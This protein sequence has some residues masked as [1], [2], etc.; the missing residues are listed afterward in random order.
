[1]VIRILVL[2]LITNT[3]FSQNNRTFRILF[4]DKN[5]SPY[6]IGQPQD[7]LSAKAIQRRTNASIPI[8]MDDL[9]IIQ[10][11]IDSVL[12]YP[13]VTLKAKSKWFNS[14]CIETDSNTL[15]QINSISFVQ[16]SVLLKNNLVSTQDDKFSSISPMRNIELYVDN[17]YGQ[18]YTQ[19]EMLN[20]HHL[21]NAGFRGEGMTIAVLDAGFPEMN[22]M[23]GFANLFAD[24]RVLGTYNFVDDT[25]DVFSNY[26]FHGTTVMS[27]M[28][29]EIPFQQ[30]GTAPKANYYF[31]ITE[32]ANSEHLLEED[33]WVEAAE[34][35]DS[36]GVDVINSS[37][38]YTTFDDS[39]LNHTYTD[40]NGST[41][42]ISRGADKAA[43]KGILVL[44]SAGNSGTSSWYYLSAPAD[45]DSILAVGAVGPDRM[46]ASFSSKGPSSDGDVKPNVAAQGFFSALI[47]PGGNLTLGSGT[48]FASPILCGM[49]TCLWQAHPDKT[50]MDILNAIQ[51][52]ASQYNSPDDYIGF[53]IPDFWKAHEI[54][55]GNTTMNYETSLIQ[56]YPNPFSNELNLEVFTDASPNAT[57]HIFDVLG[58]NLFEETINLTP[59]VTNKITL[60]DPLKLLP[61]GSYIL[62]IN[63]GDY[64]RTLKLEYIKP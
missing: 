25:V 24:G 5:N 12:S 52:S 35:A 60:S 38:G 31:F 21:H 27:C 19:I 48:S 63:V 20:G 49:A 33:N 26:H 40:M 4:T 43:S 9:P 14:I 57:V 62:Q 8:V 50:N 44:N 13:N 28:G 56:T 6:S 45:A 39:T 15:S 46:Y 23:E 3:A 11:Y 53:G 10:N 37:L 36:L 61:T 18:A 42:F 59:F 2:L 30:V 1:M 51:Q 47:W 41:T 7:F 29:A 54:L 32:D 58:R 34:K 64:V 22:T 55:L 16:N 17:Y